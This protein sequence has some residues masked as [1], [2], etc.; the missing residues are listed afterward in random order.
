MRILTLGDVTDPRAVTYLEEH[1]WAF[2]R[3]E[4]IDFTVLNAENAGFITGPGPEDAMRLLKAGADV[5]TGGNH[6]LQKKA[7]HP[8]LEEDARLLRPVNYPAEVP[9][10]GYT[11]LPANG[12]RMLVI[13]ALGRVE[14]EPIDCPFHA[15]D[16]I[17]E[18]EQG[19]Y[20]FSI[21]DFHAE[22]TGEKVGM[23]RYLDG[24]VHIIF[25]THTHVP[26]ADEQVLPHGT[27]YITDV[28][29]CGVANGVLG[30]ASEGIL[31][32]FLTRLPERYQPAEGPI[33]AQ[34]AIFTLSES[35]GRVTSVR[36][37]T[38]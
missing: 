8:L 1:L 24:R 11:I 5:L 23:G 6:T 14:M 7:L 3:A 19:Q 30:I 32:R 17:L 29:M 13:N 18:R 12:Y 9:G 15:I 25:G 28:G 4:K 34:G 35:T 21:L 2:R 10:V 37:V 31:Q 16:R 26:T 27:G 20:D 36:R 22:A 33:A 38:F